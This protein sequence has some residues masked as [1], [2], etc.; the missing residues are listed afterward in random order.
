MISDRVIAVDID[1]EFC[2]SAYADDDRPFELAL[3]VLGRQVFVVMIVMMVV[4]SGYT[5]RRTKIS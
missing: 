2:Y 4:H 1:I 3:R 5:R